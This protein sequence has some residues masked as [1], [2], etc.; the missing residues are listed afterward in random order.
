ME[1]YIYKQIDEN[2]RLLQVI[3]PSVAI[4]LSKGFINEEG[5]FIENKEH[6]QIIEVLDVSQESQQSYADY[7]ASDPNRKFDIEE[8]LLIINKK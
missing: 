5:I 3:N 7:L 4:F 6:F 2:A 1:N 8:I